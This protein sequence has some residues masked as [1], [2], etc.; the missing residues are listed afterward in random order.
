ML[1]LS[2]RAALLIDSDGLRRLA[3][4][5][6][7]LGRDVRAKHRTFGANQAAEW[8]RDRA[9]CQALSDLAPA[10]SKRLAREVRR[11]ERLGESGDRIRAGGADV[12]DLFRA[13]HLA[14]VGHRVA[15]VLVEEGINRPCERLPMTLADMT[16][17]LRGLNPELELAARFT[18]ADAFDASMAAAREEA[19]LASESAGAEQ[20]A[21][22][23]TIEER[24]GP[25]KY[26]RL[27]TAA[28]P[29][30][31]CA[32]G[33]LRLVSSEAGEHLFE[34]VL[35]DSVQLALDESAAAEGRAKAEERRVLEGL[36]AQLAPQIDALEG[37]ERWVGQIDFALARARLRSHF[38]AWPQPGDALRIDSGWVPRVRETVESSGG[39]YQPQSFDAS[40]GV[41]LLSGPNMG[42]KT[43]ALRLAGT[44]QYLAQLGY[45]VPATSAEFTWMERI[46]YV[47]SELSDVAEGLSSFAGEMSALSEVLQTERRQLVLVDEL[48]R[49]TNPREGAALADAA[50]T[51]LSKLDG[52]SVVVTHFPSVRQNESAK[53]WRVVG[54]ANADT[55]SLREDADVRGWQAALNSVMDF[56]LTEDFGNRATSDALRIAELLGV[57]GSLIAH[58]ASILGPSDDD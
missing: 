58:A 52:A 4:P 29:D 30:V 20:A 38:P 7:D 47:G 55:A 44:I 2:D 51:A 41:A 8:A 24:H 45:P 27:R 48:G 11:A 25:L 54:L 31:V 32:D 33:T 43:V 53:A 57:P 18:L 35:P 15:T 9:E 39:T 49:S 36:C 16:T 40:D 34:P 14:Y 28:A 50:V 46:D 6:S 3:E 37:L 56:A 5:L 1:T 19:V 10:A 21:F 23:A 22:Y 42:G 12:A 13:K 17:F 26:G